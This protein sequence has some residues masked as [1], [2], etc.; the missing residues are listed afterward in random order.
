MSVKQVADYL[1]LNEKKVYSLVRE[2]KI[3][4]TKITGKWIFPRELVDHWLLQSS[5]GGLLTDRLVVAGSDDPLLYHL[6]ME[7]AGNVQAQALVSYSPTGTRLGLALLA[8]LRADVGC[9]HWGPD[10]E[11]TIRHPALLQKYPQHRDWVLVRAFRREQGLIVSPRTAQ[12]YGDDLAALLQAPLSWAMRQEGAGTRRFL[13]EALTAHGI[14]PA[15]L[16][17]S[18]EALSEREAAAMVAIGDADLAPGVRASASE[19]GQRFVPI[20]WEAF[21]FALGRRIYFRALFQ[22]LLDA[23]RSP[24]ARNYAARLGGY[25]LSC[26]GNLIWGME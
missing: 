20:G 19:F 8:G 25:D 26:V 17:V 10:T 1:H 24:A 22:R 4:A 2:G 14:D 23:L 12:Q 7:L 13:Q 21:D 15:G 16:R 5:H 9:V 18:A 11:S 6:V 3:P